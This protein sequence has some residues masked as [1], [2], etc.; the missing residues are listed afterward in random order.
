ME[1]LWGQ[2]S[3]VGLL[4]GS[5][6]AGTCLFWNGDLESVFVPP[7]AAVSELEETWSGVYVDK[8]VQDCVHHA[9]LV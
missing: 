8:T 7:G 9:D 4:M 2:S 1:H 5:T 6:N 3:R